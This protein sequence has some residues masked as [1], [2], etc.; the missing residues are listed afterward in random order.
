MIDSEIYQ[1]EHDH[2]ILRKIQPEYTIEVCEK[3]YKEFTNKKTKPL[4]LA[5]QILSLSNKMIENTSEFNDKQNFDEMIKLW[6]GLVDQVAFVDYNPWENSYQK[7]SNDI[8]EP[9]SDLWRRMFVWWDGKVNPC[10][11]DYK[12]ILSPGSFENNDLKS[13]W[14]SKLYQ[15]LR[16]NH[17]NNKRNNLFPCK[18]CHVT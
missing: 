11:T 6:S 8:Q 7:P 12:S 16:E 1:C 13:L 18:N 3:C 9:C 5:K 14:N 2:K 15:K 4:F 10:D 17:I